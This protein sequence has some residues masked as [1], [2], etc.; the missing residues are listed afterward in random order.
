MT[1]LYQTLSEIDKI[2]G[3]INTHPEYSGCLIRDEYVALRNESERHS[4]EMELKGD[5]D[6]PI[7]KAGD[8]IHERDKHKAKAAKRL[9]EAQEYL[10]QNGISL[11]T[12][13]ALGL[14][15]APK[16][17][18]HSGFRNELIQFGHF[19]GEDTEK[20]SYKIKDLI[21]FLNEPSTHPVVKA[22]NAHLTFVQIHPFK[23]GNG[24]AARL[25]QNQVLLER[26]YP[27]AIIDADEKKHYI[28]MIERAIE[29]RVKNKTTIY[30]P[31][32]NELIFHDFIAEKVLDSAK[33]VDNLLASRRM[34]DV[35]LTKV[36]NFGA[37]RTL[38]SALRSE[39]RINEHGV[40]VSIDRKNGGKKESTL[41]ITGDLN[42]EKLRTILERFSKRYGFHY[43]SEIVSNRPC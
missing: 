2:L 22:S 5:L 16:S 21:D 35:T 26:G 23:D 42:R 17:N 28:S 13:S 15:I 43:T 25:L 4:L 19:Y 10:T 14:K 33:H 30:R 29:D 18:I 37:V 34:Y 32:D 8:I 31:S 20:I 39:G 24:R 36:S 6:Y 11:G 41:R 38:A 7:S 9:S 12:I 27:P 3:R 40:S 1:K